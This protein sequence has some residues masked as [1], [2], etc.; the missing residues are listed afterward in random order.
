MTMTSA[1]FGDR[2]HFLTWKSTDISQSLIQ[3]IELPDAVFC[4]ILYTSSRAKRTN[5]WCF[6]ISCCIKPIIRAEN[7]SETTLNL[8]EQRSK[9]YAWN[10]WV[11][12]T[13][14][15]I[16]FVI[17][18]IMKASHAK[19]QRGQLRFE[20]QEVPFSKVNQSFGI[21]QSHSVSETMT[22]V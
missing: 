22:P 2:L 11:I 16:V 13:I 17:F 5:I 18:C 19:H 10:R 9:K 1:F 7:C 15:S 4:T 6:S 12:N 3:A 8:Q 20:Q 14:K 21:I